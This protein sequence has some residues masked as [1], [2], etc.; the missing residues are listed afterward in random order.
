M[1]LFQVF[2]DDR[3][4]LCLE[5]KKNEADKPHFVTENIKRLN[6]KY[7]LS[8]IDRNDDYNKEMPILVSVKNFLISEDLMAFSIDLD[9]LM[10]Q[11]DLEINFVNLTVFFYSGKRIEISI[12]E[13]YEISEIYVNEEFDILDYQKKVKSGDV[14]PL[15]T[16]ERIYQEISK[17][18]QNNREKTTRVYEKNQIQNPTNMLPYVSTI[19]ENSERLKNMESY[20]KEISETLKH[21]KFNGT[22]LGPPGLSSQDGI[23][24][25]RIKRLPVKNL[26]ASKRL[27]YLPELKEIFSTTSENGGFFNFKEILKPMDAEELK[28]IVLDDEELEKKELETIS[29]QNEKVEQE[30]SNQIKLEDLK[31][32]PT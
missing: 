12:N 31:K 30:S 22:S 4:N 19:Q 29:R 25:K 1:E 18:F 3:R 16:Q 15:I 2:W 24:I 27:S 9:L 32:P 26:S 11:E 10:P 13:I 20:L 14:A 21:M 6:L 8:R 7:E 5:F 23:E 28:I 17:D